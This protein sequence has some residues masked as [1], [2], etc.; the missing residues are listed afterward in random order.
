MTKVFWFVGGFLLVLAVLLLLALVALQ[1]D[2]AVPLL[3]DRKS[4]V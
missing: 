2:D 1:R 3:Q 4:V